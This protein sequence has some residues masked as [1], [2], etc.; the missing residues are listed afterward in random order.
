MDPWDNEP[1]LL[2]TPLMHKRQKSSSSGKA[3]PSSD[4]GYL[5]ICPRY[6]TCSKEERRCL[7]ELRALGQAVPETYRLATNGLLVT[8]FCL[9]YIMRHH[10]KAKDKHNFTSTIHTPL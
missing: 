9:G 6:P 2:S 1:R 5:D 8:D 4:Q 3:P 7:Q 10:F